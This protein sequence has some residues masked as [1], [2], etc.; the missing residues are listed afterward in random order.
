M[1][2]NLINLN[3][4]V[5]NF[6]Y[7]TMK[8]ITCLLTCLVLLFSCNERKKDVIANTSFDNDLKNYA[9]ET[10][11]VYFKIIKSNNAGRQAQK[12]Y[13]LQMHIAQFIQTDR[14]DSLLNNTR[15]KGNEPITETLD[16][17]RMPA[18]YIRI[19]SQLKENDSLIIRQTVDSMFVGN[20]MYKP[21]FMKNGKLFTTTVKLYHVYKSQDEIDGPI[22]QSNYKT[23]DD[24]FNKN[25][26]DKNKLDTSKLGVIMLITQPGSGAVID[27]NNVVKVMYTGKLLDGK[28]FDS[29]MD[30]TKGREPITV[31]LTSDPSLG[32]P[33][34]PGWIDAI[35]SMK[36]GT[37]ASIYIPSPLGYGN[38]QMG[39][40]IKPNSILIFDM[41]IVEV[42][43]RALAELEKKQKMI[44]RE[45]RQKKYLDSLS[46]L[47]P[48][49]TP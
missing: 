30:T 19:L 21:P 9:K 11:G 8:K 46:R 26:I 38:Q 7:F 22:I 45:A 35:K 5:I 36:M 34:I 1:P 48:K 49:K 3:L 25:K 28:I 23:L 18:E 31:N 47:Q 4:V 6:K 20:E 10:H 33:L 39:A 12:G 2:L 14:G 41:E 44:E 24:Y 42:K 13:I 40:D 27:T 29:N 43:S 16:P 32:G 17:L 15:N 37:K